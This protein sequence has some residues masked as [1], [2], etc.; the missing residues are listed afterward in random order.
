[1][2][3]YLKKK[4]STLYF[5]YQY[6]GYKLLFILLFSLLM[7]L[8]DSFGMTLFIPLLQVSAASPGTSLAGDAGGR[9]MTAVQQLFSFLAWP[10]SLP[11][12]L[13]LIVLLF[14]LKAVFGY[15]ASKYNAIAQH[16]VSLK[17]RSRLAEGIRDLSYQEFVQTDIGRLQ[18]TIIAE[19]WKVINA[20]SQYL[21]TMT[22]VFFVLIYLGFAFVMDWRFTLLV[23]VGGG[24]SNF[25][26]KYF[27]KRT[28][29]L[30]REIT[31]NNHRYS[32]VVVELINH[33]KYLK[34]TGRGFAFFGRMQAE[35]HSL[36][37]SDIQVAKLGAKLNAIREPMTIA[38]ICIVIALHVMVFKSSLSGVMVILLFF[39]RIMQKVVDIQT[40]WNNYL[41]EVG[42][43][44]NMMDFDNYLH[45]HKEAFYKGNEPLDSI[46]T[47]NM[48]G[49]SVSY[50]EHQI[51][52]NISLEIKRNESVAFVGES[53]S[54]KTT[55]VNTIATLLPFGEGLFTINGKDIRSY[56]NRSYKKKIGYIG[57]E[58]TVFNAS[59]FENITFWATKTPENIAK[60]NRVVTMCSLD[61]F[62]NSLPER[63]E[64][65]LGNNGINVS[66]GQ[67]QRISIAR[68][69]FRDVEVLIMDEATSALD[70]ETENEI[71]ESIEALKGKLTI[72][73][74]AHRLS[75]IKNADRIFLLDK[76]KLVEQG[77]FEEL[78][79]RSNYFRKLTQLQGV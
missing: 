43:L 39:Y 15:Y 35:L 23:A 65:L 13:L 53:G 5:F 49:I 29:E 47:I 58:S 40:G 41:A 22:N 55:L 61:R 51:L 45:Q 46:A 10:V 4:F 44:E 74:I 59:I 27:Y 38:V 19:V 25:I 34:A 56:E 12:M 18:N 11:S 67:K 7:V 2:K 66:G 6:F 78:K 48:Q 75:T 71:K 31:Q 73:S 32:R 33:Y 50:A 42:A 72:I 26:Y 16:T 1:M 63:E 3:V 8:M 69:L 9:I 57:Q 20:C 70:S 14:A 54:G 21:L 28:Q 77:S 24:L 37:R 64:T 62:V 79:I 30:S 68:E 17:M 76:G 52:K 36:I 60:F